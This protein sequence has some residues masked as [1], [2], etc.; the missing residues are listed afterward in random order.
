MNDIF[1]RRQGN[2]F[3]TPVLCGKNEGYHMY[4]SA[5]GPTDNLP[6]TITH[7]FT[8]TDQKRLFRYKISQIPCGT[9]T[10]PSQGCLQYYTG[11]TGQ[12][13]SFNFAGGYHLPSHYYT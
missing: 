12:I 5:G 10:T 7:V 4:L 6:V 3:F 2:G 11:I 9:P 1:D 13:E 8:G